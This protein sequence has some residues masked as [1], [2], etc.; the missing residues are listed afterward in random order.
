[1][2][3]QTPRSA[4][5]NHPHVHGTH[6]RNSTMAL[7]RFR[8]LCCAA[9]LAAGLAARADAATPANGRWV[10]PQGL[11]SGHNG[12]TKERLVSPAGGTRPHVVMILQDDY[13]W[14]RLVV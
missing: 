9:G 1:M 5:P 13:G 14:V 7:S 8:L 3:T 4:A 10:H 6:T 12:G 11:P 2:V